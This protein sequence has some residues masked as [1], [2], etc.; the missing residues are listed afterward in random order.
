MGHAKEKLNPKL[1]LI[2]VLKRGSMLCFTVSLETVS[3]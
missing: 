2:H 3:R 1:E